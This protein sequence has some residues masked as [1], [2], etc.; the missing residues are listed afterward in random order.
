MAKVCYFTGRK[1]FLETTVH[2]MNKI[3]VPLNLTFKK[4]TPF[5]DGK[6]K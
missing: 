1:L 4:V 3:N 5:V 6:P 2:A